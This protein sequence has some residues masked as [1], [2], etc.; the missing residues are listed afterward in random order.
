M[1]YL[2]AVLL[3]ASIPSFGAST[4]KGWIS[5]SSCGVGNA[6]KAQASRECARSCIKNGAKPVLVTLKDQ[7]VLK[8]EG[9]FDAL[10]HIDHPVEVVGDLS[11]DTLK[12]AEIRKAE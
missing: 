2:A 9:K 11:G 8:L 5:D 6:D 12:V 1:R 10:A 3:C 7:K 4:F